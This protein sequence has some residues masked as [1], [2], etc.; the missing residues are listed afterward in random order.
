L[1]NLILILLEMTLFWAI[2]LQGKCLSCE[3][4]HIFNINHFASGLEFYSN[5][6]WGN[7]SHVIR[8]WDQSVFSG[9]LKESFRF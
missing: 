2:L 5:K 1:H 6:Y 4:V 7:N 3:C 9:N 8:N